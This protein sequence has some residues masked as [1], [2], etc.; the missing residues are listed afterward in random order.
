VRI[1]L[2]STNIESSGHLTNRRTGRLERLDREGCS[3]VIRFV[4]VE[5]QI[6]AAILVVST[7]ALGDV[8]GPYFTG[9]DT[10]SSIVLLGFFFSLSIAI[11]GIWFFWYRRRGGSR[12]KSWIIAS[13][14]AVG[15]FL[16]MGAV[17]TFLPLG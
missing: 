1:S 15:T 14:I 8:R 17:T 6:V 13:V 9:R 2:L 3:P 10:G 11:A 7:A 12:L 16:L 5:A 4:L